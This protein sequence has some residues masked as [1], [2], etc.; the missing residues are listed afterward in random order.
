MKPETRN[1]ASSAPIRA[2][3]F[4]I[5]M[6]LLHFDFARATRRLAPRCSAQPANMASLVWESGLVDAYDRGQILCEAFAAEAIRRIGFTGTIEEFLEAW[7]DI[8]DPIPAMF[9]RVRRWKARGLFIYLLSNT[10]EAHVRFFTDRWDIFREFDGAIYSC[11]VGSLKPEP[12]IYRALFTGHEVDPTTAVFID[13]R[14][15]NVEAARALG[16]HTSEY[17]DEATLISE[18]TPLGLD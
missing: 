12:S 6:V 8:F 10:C 13:D 2:A 18:L 1:D 16:L 7:S 11:R 4:D 15:E 17:R 5:G 14:R 9:D 3:V